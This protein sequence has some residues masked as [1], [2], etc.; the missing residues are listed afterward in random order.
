MELNN[1][2]DIYTN[3]LIFIETFSGFQN[4]P[5]ISYQPKPVFR[6]KLKGLEPFVYL[7]FDRTAEK[8]K[9]MARPRIIML[10]KA[11]GD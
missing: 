2:P 4:L 9:P 11:K 10:T 7:N 1:A 5:V 6:Q 3:F 8:I